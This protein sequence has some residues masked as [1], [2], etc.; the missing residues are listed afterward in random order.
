MFTIKQASARTGVPV[1]S[2]RAWERRY[3]V[4]APRRTES[5][6]RMYDEQA[7]AALSA[8]RRL[9]DEGWTPAT[10]AA[11]ITSGEVEPGTES[12][13][14]A[15][16]LAQAFQGPVHP[17]A[18]SLAEAFIE[19]AAAVDVAAMESVIERGFALGTFE[20]AVDAWLM[21][22]LRAL[23]DAWADGTVDVVGEHAA[24]YAIMRRLGQAFAAASSLTS[25]PRVLVG[26]PSGS[27]H[28]LGALAFATAARRRGLAVVYVGADLPVESWR[29][30]IRAFPTK[31]A[32]LAVPTAA[33]RP[34]A[35]ETAEA[36]L[37]SAPGIVVAAGGSHADDLAPGVVRLPHSIAEAARVMEELER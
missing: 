27:H 23:G 25:G 14:Q 30:A 19:A 28:E 34:K 17:E 18:E 5:G 16:R 20:T 29:R 37:H 24:S 9:V 22:T 31:I 8:M 7:I 15:A 21:P 1:A 10:A 13:Q 32:V 36:L 2:L 11:A 26:L 33:D 6:Y 35:A 4:V 3:G 12:L